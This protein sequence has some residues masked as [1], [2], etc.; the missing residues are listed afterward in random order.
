[1]DRPKDAVAIVKEGQKHRWW[2][3]SDGRMR[4]IAKSADSKDGP[5]SGPDSK[6]T[7]EG[8]RY[9]IRPTSAKTRRTMG[10]RKPTT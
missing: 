8:T 3:P 10:A 1:M 7:G 6:N 5:M 2:K 9:G 4:A